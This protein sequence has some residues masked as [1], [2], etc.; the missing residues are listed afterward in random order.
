MR[1]NLVN[2]KEDRQRV[3]T[4]EQEGRINLVN[5]LKK[6]GEVV[7]FSTEEMVAQFFRVPQVTITQIANRRKDELSKY[8]Y[9]TYKKSEILNIQDVCLE[10]VPNRGLR[11][12]SIKAVILIGMMLTESE[13]AEQ[14]R[15]DIMD[16]LF[17]N[18]VAIPTENTIRNVVSTELDK[19]VPQLVGSKDVQVKAIVK[20]IKGN[21]GIKTK[22]HNYPDYET[23]VAWLMAKYG[24]YKLEDIPCSDELFININNFTRKLKKGQKRLF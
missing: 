9:R 13:V 8:G 18:E 2:S 17:G 23:T 24:V 10:N 15:S 20:A 1:L 16:I 6:Y 4:M 3:L 12:Y 19:R 22:K 11:L 21:L 14:L 7:D 5:L